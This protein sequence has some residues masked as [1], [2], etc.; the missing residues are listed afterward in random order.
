MFSKHP[1]RSSGRVNEGDWEFRFAKELQLPAKSRWAIWRAKLSVVG[2]AGGSFK[3]DDELLKW[4]KVIHFYKINLFCDRTSVHTKIML[5]STICWKVAAHCARPVALSLGCTSDE[6]AE[7]TKRKFTKFQLLKSTRIE[8][9]KVQTLNFRLWTFGARS[10][11]GTS[12]WLPHMLR[13]NAIR[14][15][16]T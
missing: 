14:Q 15:S 16:L 3:L 12:R 1:L 10:F 4:K 2:N 13:P 11:N 7:S 6:A 9:P 5:L 8:T